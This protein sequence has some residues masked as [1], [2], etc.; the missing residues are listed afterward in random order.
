MICIIRLLYLFASEFT[1]GGKVLVGYNIGESY[2]ELP[3]ISTLFVH[4]Q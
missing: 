3:L 1:G 2:S 4:T